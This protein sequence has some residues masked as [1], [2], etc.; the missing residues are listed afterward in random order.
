[1]S[2]R[3]AGAARPAVAVLAA[4]ATLLAGCSVTLAPTPVAP[5]PAFAWT[6]CGDLECAR[7]PVPL[8]HADPLGPTLEL[9]VARRSA[10]RTPRLGTLFVN[11]GGPGAS[12]RSMV[13]GV[14]SEGLGQFDVVGWDP[15]GVGESS[16]VTCLTGGEADADDGPHDRV[17]THA[18]VGRRDL[19]V[20]GVLG[21]VVQAGLPRHDPV[22][23]GEHDRQRHRDRRRRVEPLGNP[24]GAGA[25]PAAV[26]AG[27]RRVPRAAGHRRAVGDHAPHRLGV[28]TRHLTGDHAAEAPA[29][30]GGRPAR[31]RHQLEHAVGQPVDVAPRVAGVGAEAPAPGVVPQSPQVAPQRRPGCLGRP[32]TRH[33]HDEVAVA[34]GCRGEAGQG[35]DQSDTAEQGAELAECRGVVR[36]A[37]GEAQASHVRA[38]P[39]A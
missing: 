24:A 36:R 25:G 26:G 6:P 20:L 11:P 18:D 29:D 13:L 8:D 34:T 10:T 39:R 31:V 14:P 38:G 32:P 23:A 28:A 4:A 19:D 9:A 35:A 37:A 30:Q 16:A 27:D 7:V 3:R 33:V 5:T 2:A 21:R 12:G 1:M 22:P 15:R 17:E